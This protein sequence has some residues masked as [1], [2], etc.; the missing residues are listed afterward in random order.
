ML[1]GCA[2]FEG[3]GGGDGE[4]D[5]VQGGARDVGDI[6]DVQGTEDGGTLD[7]VALDADVNVPDACEPRACAPTD[8]GN[9]DDGCGDTLNCTAGCACTEA[10][11]N[12]VCPPRPCQTVTGCENAV[13]VYAPVT[14]GAQTCLP[15]ACEGDACELLC[16]DESCTE[17]LYPCGDARCAGIEQFC[18]PAPIVVSGQIRYANTCV[19]PPTTGCGTCDLGRRSCD[20]DEDRFVCD[21]L[22]LPLRLLQDVVCDSEAE[23]STLIFVDAA[24]EGATENGSRSAPYRTYDSA[25]ARAQASGRPRG[26]II[27]GSPVFTDPLTIVNGVSI[28]GGFGASPEF[29][30]TS[31]GRPRWNIGLD[32][33]DATRNELTGALAQNIEASTVISNV[34][35]RTVDI[36]ASRAG[37][38]G[39]SNVALR[40]TNASGLKLYRVELEAGAAGH[41]LDGPSGAAPTPAMNGGDGMG[42]VPGAAP[43]ACTVAPCTLN[44]PIVRQDIMQC[45]YG[46]YGAAPSFNWYAPNPGNPGSADGAVLGGAAGQ[47]VGHSG[48]GCGFDP[49]ELRPG[50]RGADAPAAISGNAGSS[51]G[52]PGL[53]AQGRWQPAAG[54]DGQTGAVGSWGGGGGGGG[55][56]ND[57]CQN[58]PHYGGHGAGGGAPGCGGNPGLGGGG[59]GASIALVALE[60]TAIA[61]ESSILKSGDGGDG[62]DGGIGA[63]GGLGGRGET[64]VEAICIVTEGG[65]GGEFC[66]T[67]GG[68]GGNGSPGGA[69][70]D[71]GAGSGGYS[72]GMYCVDTAPTITDVVRTPGTPG[73]GG[74]MPAGASAGLAGIAEGQIGCE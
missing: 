8:C 68:A 26:I 36:P 60:S 59:G 11:F 3:R 23:E 10:D 19:A 4:P 22:N 30:P 69:G 1:A 41:G 72:V 45:G 15:A 14:C 40:A 38:D 56:T 66:A 7:D 2:L 34:R 31:T 46:A 29:A 17:G 67:P 24:Y 57:G 55:G 47:N 27:A 71:G 9:V 6:P 44:E 35:I 63:G 37:R 33:Y 48:S 13:C 50:G 21:N 52:A 16:D 73:Q 74:V 5:D 65:G 64:D 70:G 61:V 51:A 25:L 58:A 43:S 32:H 42:R 18:D 53:D 62:G 12:D 49:D 28:Y 20:I 39:A 54:E